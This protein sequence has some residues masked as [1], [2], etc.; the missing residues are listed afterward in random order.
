MENKGEPS[1]GTPSAAFS[2]RGFLKA[3]TTLAA[4]GAHMPA[5]AQ[6]GSGQVIAYVGAYTDRGK[7]IHMFSVDPTDGTLTPT[8]FLSPGIVNP[9]ALAFHP[10]KKFLYAANEIS[11]YSGPN[12]TGSVT[13]MSVDGGTGDLRIMNVVSS[14]GAGPAHVSVDPSGKWLFA[15]NYGA[16]SAAVIPIMADG[17]LGAATDVKKISGPLGTSNPAVEAPPGSFANSGHDAPHAHAA[18]SDPGG[19]YVF[20]S[21][22]GTDRITFTLSTKREGRS[23]PPTP[24]LCKA[25]GAQGPATLCSIRTAVWFTRSQRRLRR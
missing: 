7:G 4:V 25:H 24:N 13:S 6:S 10:N 19:N 1:T 18:E 8:R 9:S 5:V 15:A 17:S 11:N 16:G 20:V 21:D 22:L 2:R 3:S 12:T 14:G 23:H